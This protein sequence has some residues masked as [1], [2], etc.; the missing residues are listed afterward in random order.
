MLVEGARFAFLTKLLLVGRSR[1]KSRASL[2]AENLFLAPAGDRFKRQL[3][4]QRRP[5]HQTMIRISTLVTVSMTSI[6]SSSG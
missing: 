4:P 5:C 6:R 3:R 2:E 1:L